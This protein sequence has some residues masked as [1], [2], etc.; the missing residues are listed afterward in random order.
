MLSY[1][2]QYEQEI[3]NK[4]FILKHVDSKFWSSTFGIFVSL[5]LQ[6]SKVSTIIVLTIKLQ[7]ATTFSNFFI[8]LF[9]SRKDEINTVR[10]KRPHSI[11]IGRKIN[12][13]I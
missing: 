8:V 7:S 11:H 2:L 5:L 12:Q 1:H 6:V 9:E 10:I 13:K 4:V 3:L